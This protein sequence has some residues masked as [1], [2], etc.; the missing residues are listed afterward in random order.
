L[1]RGKVLAA[2]Q[3]DNAEASPAMQ[4]FVWVPVDLSADWSTA[5]IL[6][7]NGT[8]ITLT[9]RAG[10]RPE[11]VHFIRLSSANGFPMGRLSISAEV[12]SRTEFDA[13]VE[14]PNGTRLTV[15]LLTDEQ[16][17]QYGTDVT[18]DDEP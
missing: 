11:H 14:L 17:Q 9:S 16:L 2:P 8:P 18:Q 4:L 13:F 10:F 15:K 1:T 6:A 3:L 7:A 5:T 12:I